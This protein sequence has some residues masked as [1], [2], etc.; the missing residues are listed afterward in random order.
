MNITEINVIIG[1]WGS[2]NA[3]NER[4]LGSKWLNFADYDSWEDIEE[5]LKKQSFKLDGIDE[6][7]FIQDIEDFPSSCTNWDDMSPEK[8][9]NT[10]KYSRVCDEA[11]KYEVMQAYLKVCSLSEFI[12]LVDSK[13]SRWDDDIHLYKGYSWEEYGREMFECC[14]IQIDEKLLN[15]FDFEAY[16]KYI[17]SDYA[18]EY[19]DGIIEIIR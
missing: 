13:G 15:F 7:L 11:Y 5:E 18:E 4:A 2:Y 9:F 10:L 3:C 12:E 1:S 14:E 8:L 6:E 16:G 17:G 19:S